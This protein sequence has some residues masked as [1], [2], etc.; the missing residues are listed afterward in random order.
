M[1]ETLGKGVDRIV[2][3]FSPER[4]LRRRYFRERVKRTAK[5]AAAKTP[6][7]TGAWTPT[8]GGVNQIINNSWSTTTS[9]VR[10]LVRDF[11]HFARAVDS[12]VTYTV[13]DGILYQSRI[14]NP[15][16]RKLDKKKIQAAEDFFAF[17]ADEADVAG[18][19]HYYE[20]MQLAKRQDAESGEF[21]LIETESRDR[22]R[23]L[24]YALQ[25]IEADWLTTQNDNY[26]GERVGPGG[27][28][29]TTVYQGIEYERQT[30]RIAGYW[31]TDPDGWGNPIR[32]PAERVIHGF[33]T[34]RPGQLRGISIFAP[35]VLIAKDISNYMDAEIDAAQMAAKY[36]AFVYYDD[37]AGVQT[38][39]TV[40]DDESGEYI[41]EMENAIV[42]YLNKG[43]KVQIANPNRPSSN[44]APFIE[45]CLTMVSITSG[46]PFEILTAK[47]QGL[48]YSVS[49]AKRN[50]FAKELK[51]IAT[52]HVRQF[53]MP[54]LRGAFESGVM[55]GKLPFRDFFSNPYVYLRAEWQPPGM[56]SLDPLRESKAQ[57]DQ[58]KAMLRSPQELA[59]ARG[60]DL[61]DIYSEIAEAME[62]AEE[63]GLDYETAIG[64]I[65]TSVK[66][67][68]AA[69]EGQRGDSL[70]DLSAQ[71]ID[72]IDKVEGMR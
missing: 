2:G 19:L 70:S 34:L 27:K 16:D 6:R 35:A 36:L 68:P 40:Y 17:W 13:G 49:R 10:Q 63:K 38:D 69:V 28:S 44:F 18:K 3:V 15:D 61:E 52:R 55:N 22:K 65:N 43:E 26:D 7:G 71:V 12:I 23:F 48:N 25:A 66:N 41:E 30:G 1:F 56:E 8:S 21:M 59:K 53:G 47:Y 54:T 50:D 31:I 32:I 46:I 62:L 37:P 24:P 14:K 51:P 9:R 64:L 60:R 42:E 45:F 20:M 72:L 11:P 39:R 5:Y 33:R 67:N 29:G 57:I 4:E 58:V